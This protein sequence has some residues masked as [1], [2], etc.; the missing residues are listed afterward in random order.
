MF[1][2]LEDINR[3]PD[4]YSYYTAEEL[5]TNEHTAKQMLHF[6]LKEDVDLSSRNKNF[7]EKSVKWIGSRFNAGPEIKIADFGCGPGL[8]SSRLA[9]LGA[10]VTGID[11][12]QNSIE[13]AKKVA[14][15]ENRDIN[16]INQNYL[17]FNTDSRF[18]LII[19]IMCDFCALSP[20]QR[21]VML[22][23][24][25]SLLKPGGSVLLDVYSLNAFDQREENA[26]YE[27]N[28]LF[29][30]WSPDKYYGFLN[31][32]KYEKEKVTLDKYSIVDLNGIKTVYNWLQH[33]SVESL[34]EEFVSAGFEKFEITGN[35]AGDDYNPEASEFAIIA[36]I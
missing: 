7:I 13:Y 22:N 11:F 33:F 35:V 23:K 29:G 2:E 36:N 30:F 32:F 17:E 18:D 5:W 26:T 25:R 20:E 31:T 1:K 6:H 4:C 21:N 12:S 9:K 3:R 10:D 14:K 16:Y 19:M 8:Y 27:E 28:Q 15:S 24:F 34:K